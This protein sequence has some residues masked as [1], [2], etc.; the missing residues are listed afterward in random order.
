MPIEDAIK[1][2]TEIPAKDLG[3]DDIGVL[4]EGRSADFIVLD[5]NLNLLATVIDGKLANGT[6]EF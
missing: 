6:L 2:M 5:E 1:A 4:E 3:L